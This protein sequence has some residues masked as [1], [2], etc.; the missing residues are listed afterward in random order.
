MKL[1][2]SHS[3]EAMMM[4]CNSDA[5]AERLNLFSCDEHPTRSWKKH[6]GVFIICD[7]GQNVGALVEEIVSLS[8]LLR[9]GIF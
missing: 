1:V 5:H 4:K 9:L 2:K 8:A 6:F 3:I 7:N